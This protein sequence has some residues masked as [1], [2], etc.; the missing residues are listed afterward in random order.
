MTVPTQ[1]GALQTNSDGSTV[2]TKNDNSTVH[3]DQNH[4]VTEVDRANGTKEVFGYDKDGNVTSIKSTDADGKEDLNAVKPG[5]YQV[6]ADG[7][8]HA[9]GDTGSQTTYTDGTRVDADK[10]GKVMFIVNNGNV[11]YSS[12]NHSGEPKDHATTWNT[13]SGTL[14]QN[15]DGTSKFTEGNGTVIDISK[16]GQVSFEDASGK[17]H[18]GSALESNG[19]PQVRHMTGE[20]PVPA[21]L[22]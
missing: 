6:D 12:F 13:D 1:D 20:V 2:L 19:D 5:Q 9:K 11:L 21:G 8:V 4:R 17:S 3:T 16:G 22:Q 7:T 18:P 15:S 14:Q 10:T